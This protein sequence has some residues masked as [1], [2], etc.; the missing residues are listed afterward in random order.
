M[1]ADMLPYGRVLPLYLGRSVSVLLYKRPMTPQL[2]AR[3]CCWKMTPHTG[4]SLLL[5]VTPPAGRSCE[6]LTVCACRKWLTLFV[7]EGVLNMVEQ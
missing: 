4:R 3:R 7:G 1:H 5:K 2:C 6:V